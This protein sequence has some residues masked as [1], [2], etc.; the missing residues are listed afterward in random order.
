MV[1]SPPSDTPGAPML[2]RLRKLEAPIPCVVIGAGAM[3][4]G[5]FAQLTRTP[6]MRCL[7]LA[8]LDLARCI[9]CA[10]DLGLPWREV[11]SE[12]ELAAAVEAGAVA[13]STDGALVAGCPGAAVVVEATSAILAG[14]RH[15]LTAIERGKHLVLMN[16]EIDLAFGPLLLERARAAGVCLSSCDGD[17][18]ATLE[19]LIRDLELWG[20]ELVMAGNIKG[21]LD[22]T[23]NPTS[24][25]PEADKRNLDY[26]MCTAYTDGTKLCIEMALIANAR[27]LKTPV[28]GMHGPRAGHVREVFALFDLAGM[29]E[30][31]GP[32][33]DYILGAEPGGGVFAI[34]HCDDRYQRDMLRYYKMGEGPFYLFYRPY[35]LCHVEAMDCIARAAL[36]RQPLLVPAQGMRAEVYAYAKRDLVAGESLDG[37]GGYTCYGLI[38]NFGAVPD[39]IPMCL[40]HDLPLLRDLPQGSRLQWTD[41]ERPAREDLA[42][43]EQSLAAA[44]R[45]A[46]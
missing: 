43:Y 1:W 21:F 33:V 35:H 37:L 9:A 34:G 6:G 5:L 10:E 18:H 22:R 4:R 3:G 12:G 25:V 31:H 8:D 14:A 20:F 27:G 42:L 36:D 44:R 30:E 39:G 16:S 11:H 23:A 2:E 41:V 26:R 19:H 17:Q 40:A 24:I 32:V 13:L 38:E 7:A 15:A 45:M 46:G 28:P 29:W